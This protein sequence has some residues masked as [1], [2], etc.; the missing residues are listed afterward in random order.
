MFDWLRSFPLL[1]LALAGLPVADEAHAQGRAFTP[2]MTCGQV[3]DLVR[4]QG[5]VI[6]SP[7]PGIYDRYVAD[8]RFCLP[9]DDRLEPGH[10]PTRDRSACFVGYRCTPR[11][12]II[13]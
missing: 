8:A 12:E 13:D 2:A 4:R 6:L 11:L 1:A 9:P 5:A 7:A 3:V 10:L